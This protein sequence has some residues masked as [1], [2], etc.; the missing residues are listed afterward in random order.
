[1]SQILSS[2]K[3]IGFSGSR[4]QP[5]PATLQAIKTAVKAIPAGVPVSVGCAKGVD[6]IVRNLLPSARVFAVADL[7]FSGRG[8][9]AAR[10]ISCVRSVAVPQ[11]VWCA[12]PSRPCPEG[13]TPSASP[14]RCFCGLAS[15]TWASLAFAVGLGVACLVFL[16]PP[17]KPPLGW[18]FT[19]GGGGWFLIP[20]APEQLAL[21]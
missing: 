17:I 10:S 6:Q 5:C 18:G 4:S 20:S 12:F 14:S 8:A 13:L 9:L 3:A 1:M 2:A 21:F 7:N 11:G 16:P 15:G 19:S